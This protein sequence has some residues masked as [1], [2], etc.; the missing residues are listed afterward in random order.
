ME[1]RLQK[2]LARAGIASRREAE[3]LIQ[4]GRVTVNGRAVRE[5]GVKVDPSMDE[6]RFDT[7]LVERS[8]T[9]PA[10]KRTYLLLNKPKGVI[11]T[12]KDTHGRATV[13]DLV[14]PREGQR[15]WPVG[16]LDEDSEGIVLL[17][18]DGDLTDRLTHPRYGVPKVYDVR[19]RGHVSRETA[20]RFEQGV[21]LSEGKTGR[22]RVYIRRAG[23][24]VSHVHITLTE[25][26]NREIRRA[27][28]KLGLNVLSI[29]R[30]QIG[31]IVARGLDVGM[32]RPLAAAEVEA[33]RAAAQGAA[34]SRPMR[35]RRLR[36]AQHAAR[37]SRRRSGKPDPASHAP[38]T[39]RKP[40]G[41]RPR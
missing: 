25:G 11:C 37:A 4:E 22:S 13:L 20:E 27:W 16:R 5:L 7:V 41:R 8:Q 6:I 9:D 35:G 38:K 18:D 3:R 28:A 30:I 21:W 17:T 23:R 34:D 26:R 19:L 12:A 31:P 32:F 29:K 1:E 14:P 40:R 10:A 15:L 33:L 39:P 36:E 24:E 2:V